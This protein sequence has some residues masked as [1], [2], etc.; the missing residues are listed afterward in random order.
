MRTEIIQNQGQWPR[1]EDLLQ[2]WQYGQFLRDLDRNIVRL[3]IFQDKRPFAAAQGV[4]YHVKPMVNYVYF[5]RVKI[6]FDALE[7]IID[8]F[9]KDKIDFIRLEPVNQVS[10]N[11]YKIMPALNRQT[12]YTLILDISDDEDQIIKRMHYKT[13]YNIRLAERKGVKVDR[14]QNIDIFWELY[15]STTKRNKFKIHPKNFFEKLLRQDFSYQLNAYYQDNVLASAILTKHN[16]TLYY[17]FGASAD[18]QRNFMAPYLMHWNAIKFGK[19]LGCRSYDWWGIAKPQQKDD[20]RAVCFND[21]CWDST[22]PF[23]SVT[24]FKA[25]FGGKTKSY[26]AA[27][28][29]VLDPFKYR[30]YKLIQKIKGN[31]VPVGHPDNSKP[32][33]SF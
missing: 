26:P 30:L 23:S 28:D 12:R 31:P 27:V 7:A 25:G 15:Q 5:P 21:I 24:R 32:Q 19:E 1:T 4:V 14:E 13:R 18:V 33:V 20:R 3:G 22:H 9:N 6:N 8:Y 16:H 2:S 17:F 10:L 11:N 29:I